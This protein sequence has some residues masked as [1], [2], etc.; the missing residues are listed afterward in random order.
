MNCWGNISKIMM[1]PMGR[2]LACSNREIVDS[3]L[4]LFAF[5][6]NDA[7]CFQKLGG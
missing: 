1:K 2:P 6:V 7:M 4:R 3:V 5:G